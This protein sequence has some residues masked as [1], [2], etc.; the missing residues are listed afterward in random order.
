M[1]WVQLTTGLML[2]FLTAAGAAQAQDKNTTAQNPAPAGSADSKEADQTK[3]GVYKSGPGGIRT[4]RGP[5]IGGG[6]GSG[7][8]AASGSAGNAAAGG[9]AGGAGGAAAGGGAGAGAGGG[10]GGGGGAGR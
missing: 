6:S 4:S 2:A 1:Q 7:G 8:P 9:N 10:A 5:A 3:A